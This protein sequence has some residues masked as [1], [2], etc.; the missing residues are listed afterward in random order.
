MIIKGARAVALVLTAVLV[1]AMTACAGAAP[2]GAGEATAPPDGVWRSDGYGWVIAVGGGRA[3]T[4]ETT[5]IS[6]LPAETLDQIGPPGADGTVRY[7]TDG[8][9][10]RTVRRTADGRAVL[11]PLGTVS[12]IDLLPLP[13]LPESCSRPVPNDP[14]TNFDIFW[15]TFA[16]HYN[17]FG[18]KHVDWAAVRERYRPQVTPRTS[19]AELFTIFT[20][21]LAPLGDAHTSVEGKG[22]LEFE[23]L[24]AGTRGEDAVPL[25]TV[26]TSIDAHLR[27]DLGVSDIQRFAGGHIAYADLPGDLGY[28]RI[29]S[30][31][32]WQGE[33]SA[34]LADRAE[35]DRALAAVFTQARVAKW[36]G[37]TI[38]L[39][40]NSGGSDALGIQIAGH[41][42]DRAYPAYTKQ[43]RNDP[44]DQ[45]RHGRLLTITVTPSEGPRYTGP[46]RLLTSDLTVS[47]GETFTMALMGRTPAPARVGTTTQGVFAD[48]MHRG[49]PNGL[50][51][52]LGNEEFYLPDGRSFEG[53]GI[54]PTVQRDVFTPTDLHTHKDAALDGPF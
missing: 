29:T 21:M 26:T 7:G 49:L 12:E 11:H 24:R 35:L 50:S 1:P 31:Q 44:N 54:P 19:R 30:F 38:D 34:Y 22:D 10:R 28:L 37:L 39:R 25:K 53:T 47:A 33:D 41:L 9:A 45:T 32:D 5:A 15:T 2:D 3:R 40:H 48:D 18:R 46:L 20:A 36:R 13:G 16:E 42:T 8:V 43:A 27:A 14:V 4:F 52:G 51:F 6:C 17:S 23:G